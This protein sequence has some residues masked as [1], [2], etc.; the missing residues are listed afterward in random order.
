MS[1]IL[2]R[3]RADLP[4]RRYAHINIIDE[5]I[6]STPPNPPSPELTPG[7]STQSVPFPTN[8]FDSLYRLV[9][10]LSARMDTS[11]HS[12][13]DI[14][15]AGWN[16][17]DDIVYYSI[18]TAVGHPRDIH[19]NAQYTDGTAVSAVYNTVQRTYRDI[20]VNTV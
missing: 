12:S 5:T 11:I 19:L 14:V 2:A 1:A 15:P 17:P 13:L 6:P 3:K 4:P 9:D 18:G 10:K 8:R 7:V 16:R 20:T